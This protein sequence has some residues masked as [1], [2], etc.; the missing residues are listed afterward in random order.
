[1]TG[2]FTGASLALILSVLTYFVLVDT[3]VT[4]IERIENPSVNLDGVAPQY[5]PYD[6]PDKGD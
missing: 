3:T 1:M 2:F 4:S 6:V 5:P